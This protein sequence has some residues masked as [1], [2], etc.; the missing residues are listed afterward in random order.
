V[1]VVSP[2][3]Q[4]LKH[5]QPV[6]IAADSFAID[7][8]GSQTERI[9]GLDDQREAGRPVVAIASEQADASSVVL[10][11]ANP[12]RAARRRTEGRAR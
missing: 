4:L 6:V 1:V 2:L 5:R 9:D 7:Q 3:P 11:L 8:A 10:E 12:V